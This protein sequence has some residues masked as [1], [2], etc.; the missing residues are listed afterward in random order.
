MVYI[1]TQH[2]THGNMHDMPDKLAISFASNLHAPSRTRLRGI[3]ACMPLAMQQQVCRSTTT[4]S[5]KFLVPLSTYLL[6]FYNDCMGTCSTSCIDPFWQMQLPLA[7][8]W[9][10]PEH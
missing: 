1:I 4:L 5:I 9:L 3:M 6:F 8:S 10:F 2:V 7:V